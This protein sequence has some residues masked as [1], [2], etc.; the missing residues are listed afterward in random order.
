[1]GKVLE[2][3]EIYNYLKK[4]LKKE[5][6][7]FKKTLC[8]ASLEI[9]NNYSSQLYLSVQER[10]A[11]D[12]GVIY[13]RIKISRDSS[14]KAVVKKIHQLNQDRA[15]TGI[16]INRPFAQGWKEE[17]ILSELDPLKD[18]EGVSPY[19]LGRLCLGAPLFVS[20]TV[21]SILEL[22]KFT[23]IGLYAKEVTL[24]GFSN[25]IG[26]P[27]TLILCRELATINITHI[28]TYERGRLR[29]YIKN[30][31]I[32]ISA[33]GKPYFIKG[34]WIK[35]GAVVIDVGTAQENGK[36]RGDI[37]F[38]RAKERA[39]WISPVPGG[40][41]KLTPLFLFKNLLRA[42]RLQLGSKKQ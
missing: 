37:E 34:A 17:T 38:E 18:I 27:L 11:Q 4:G 19:N 28:A 41:G 3:K 31:D 26:K 24:V 42:G 22:I 9:E 2:A 21:L 25:I 16:I 32:L 14:L 12:L 23:Q 8:L 13:Q 15:V 1:M 36:V 35:K 29:F 39:S 10:L 40:V 6:K 7:D 20:P 30:A 33:V 5:I